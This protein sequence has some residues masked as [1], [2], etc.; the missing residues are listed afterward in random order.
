MVETDADL[1]LEELAQA[2]GVPPRTIRFYQSRGALPRP[3]RA[4]RAAFYNADHRERLELIGLLQDRGL[5][6][7]SIRDLLSDEG[8]AGRSVANW[9]GLEEALGGPWSEDRPR[10]MDAREL[11]A[12][13]GGRT[14]VV[15]ELEHAGYLEPTG[16]GRAWLVPSPTLVELAL[17]LR[18]A[19][20]DVAVSAAA[21]DLLRRRLARAADD[22][23]AL[24]SDR[25][26]ANLGQLSPTQLADVIE[27]LRPIARQA[28]GLVLPQ[29]I[30]RSVRHVVEHPPPAR[31]APRR[32]G[33]RPGARATR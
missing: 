11:E 8:R 5:K 19:G 13:V 21:R 15:A 2:T 29:E 23:V 3:R 6:L 20:V 25:T 24:F 30:E 17:R 10:V 4:G 32:S 22:L 31:S 1:T 14:G 18:D 12:L 27:V 16:D 26:G 28:A 7:D 9:L 33:R